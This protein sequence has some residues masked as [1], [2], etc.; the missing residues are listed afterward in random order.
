MHLYI[1]LLFF[2]KH[3]YIVNFHIFPIHY[4][5]QFIELVNVNEKEKLFSLIQDY[6]MRDITQEKDIKNHYNRSFK[7]LKIT[8]YPLIF[9]ENGFKKSVCFFTFAFAS[10]ELIA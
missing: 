8:Y 3:D 4:L 2:N 10:S 7:N 5:F 9:V 6:L 1:K